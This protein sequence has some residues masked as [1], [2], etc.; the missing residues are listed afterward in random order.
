MILINN[1][2]VKEPEPTPAPRDFDLVIMLDSSVSP[3]I[4]QWMKNFVSRLS[5]RLSIDDE[6]FRVGVM[7]YST[8]SNVEFNLDEY[9]TN[10]GV[11]AGVGDVTYLPGPRT[12]TKAINFVR[13][14]MFTTANGDRPWARNYILLL[15]GERQRCV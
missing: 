7:V 3:D 15:T 5:S 6:K 4:F 8:G 11:L 2:S 12:T 14:R 10:E 1:I 9:N 13:Q